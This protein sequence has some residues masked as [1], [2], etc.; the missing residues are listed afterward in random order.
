MKRTILSSSGGA[1]VHTHPES[2]V[3]ALGT[4][5]AARLVKASN[6]SDLAN[7]ATARTNLGLS[8]PTLIV[9]PSV[10]MNPNAGAWPTANRALYA[11]FYLPTPTTLR[12]VNWVVSTQSGNVQVGVVSLSGSDRTAF[13]RLMDSGVIACPAA[14]DQHTD[15]GATLLP[16]GDYAAYLWADN[17]TFQTRTVS[18]SAQ[19]VHR[20]A[21]SLTG[22]TT[23]V[24][25]SGTLVWGAQIVALS[26]SGD[27]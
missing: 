25:T 15:L 1:G 6:L 14:G 18:A 22:L 2:D 12:Y 13:T 9:P 10:A 4:D 27:V 20:H 17:V 8:A 5:L 3:T 11:R 21:G 19:T 16:A 26:V 24:G 7:A 23:G